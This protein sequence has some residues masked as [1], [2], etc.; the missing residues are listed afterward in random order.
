MEFILLIHHFVDRENFYERCTL[1]PVQKFMLKLKMFI[2]C[3]Q[4]PEN[5]LFFKGKFLIVEIAPEPNDILWENLHYCTKYKVKVRIVIYS[6]A[7]L[8]LAICF[9]IILGISFGQVYNIFFLKSNYFLQTQ[10]AL[11]VK[12]KSYNLQ[13]GVSI[14]G[15]V[16]SFVIVFII[17]SLSI[18]LKM[19]GNLEKHSTLTHLKISNAIKLSC[20]KKNMFL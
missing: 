4:Q 18:V 11:D 14:L 2:C 13:V 7:L 16:V 12:Q 6:F 15:V 1:T 9:G 3:K 20:V 5:F 17:V 19:F 8:M 10:A